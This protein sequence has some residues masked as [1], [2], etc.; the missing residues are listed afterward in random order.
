MKSFSVGCYYFVHGPILLRNM[1][2]ALEVLSTHSLQDSGH[3]EREKKLRSIR[4]VDEELGTHRFGVKL[5]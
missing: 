4:V 1:L 3:E 2:S 5:T